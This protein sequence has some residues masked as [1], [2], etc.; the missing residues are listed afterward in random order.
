MR[1]MPSLESETSAK[2]TVVNGVFVDDGMKPVGSMTPAEIRREKISIWKN[3][4]VI[5]LSFMCLFT[6]YNSVANLQVLLI[7]C[8]IKPNKKL[9]YENCYYDVKSS[10]NSIDGLGTA[11]QATVYAALIVSCMFVPTW[12]IK[13]IKCKWTLVV[14]QLCYSAYICAQ[15]Y[16]QFYTLIPAAIIVGFGAAPM[17]FAFNLS[18]KCSSN[19]L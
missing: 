4:A 7:E 16:A 3:V 9:I 14:C 12:M 10:I 8:F 2:V 13:T 19:R 15:F 5:S 18:T 1:E 6:A 17:V 11:S